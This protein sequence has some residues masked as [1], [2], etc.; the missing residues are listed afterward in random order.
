[1]RWGTVLL[2][3]ITALTLSAQEMLGHGSLAE[4]SACVACHKEDGQARWTNQRWR[5]CTP[6]CLSCHSPADT[7]QHH[8]VGKALRKPLTVPLPLGP[9]EVMACRTCHDLSRAREDSV[10]WRAESL[11]GRLFRRQSRHKTYFLV[12]RNDRGQLCL[13]CH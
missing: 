10:R 13:A 7:A 3:T 9:G 2:A 6:F 5:A 1:M 4:P 12:Q 8:P 11:Y